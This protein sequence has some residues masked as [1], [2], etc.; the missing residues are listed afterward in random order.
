MAQIYNGPGMS[1]GAGGGPPISVL[2]TAVLLRVAG[3]RAGGHDART[4]QYLAVYDRHA[5][6]W[7]PVAGTSTHL[8]ARAL[9]RARSHARCRDEPPHISTHTLAVLP[10]AQRSRSE[11]T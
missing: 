4:T 11:I 7:E 1:P 6:H 2:G 9:P 10:C 5:D 3:H 8:H